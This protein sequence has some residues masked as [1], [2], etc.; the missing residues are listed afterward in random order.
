M[1]A[2]VVLKRIVGDWPNVFRHRRCS[3]A[4]ISTPDSLLIGGRYRYLCHH[5]TLYILHLSTTVFAT[6]VV[7]IFRERTAD[8]RRSMK[9]DGSP[10]LFNQLPHV[11]LSFMSLHFRDL[12]LEVQ[13]CLRPV[14]SN[15]AIAKTLH[16][17]NQHPDKLLKS[18]KVFV[19]TYYSH[20]YTPITFS[21]SEPT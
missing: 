16:A 10:T 14:M 1:I 4:F 11:V 12:L 5:T 15:L 9:G 13:E 19:Q 2:V 8:E 21:I 17:G 3:Q 18:Q 20:G 7:E 6:I